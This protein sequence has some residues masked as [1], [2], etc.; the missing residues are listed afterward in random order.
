MFKLVREFLSDGN[1]LGFDANNDYSVNTA[2]Q[3]GRK[4]EELGIDHFEEPIPH[5]DL[6]GLKQVADALDV[7]VSAGEQDAYR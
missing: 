7:S 5:Y 1:Y 6:P 3:Q 2:I 4:F